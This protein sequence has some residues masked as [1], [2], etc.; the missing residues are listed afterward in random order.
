MRKY[1]E[2]FTAFQPAPGTWLVT[3]VAGFI[4]SDLLER[5]LLPDQEVVGLHNFAT[6]HRRNLDEVRCLAN[7]A[8]WAVIPPLVT[9]FFS[10]GLRRHH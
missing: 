5:L 8:Q 6:G 9:A 10:R 2:C 7:A 4:G 1:S 3:G